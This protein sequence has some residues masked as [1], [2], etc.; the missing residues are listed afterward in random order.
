VG[1]Y[2]NG[3]EALKKALEEGFSDQKA[4]ESMIAEAPPAI[5]PAIRS[6]LTGR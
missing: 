3:I 4:I 1:N 6:L 2:Q 5:R